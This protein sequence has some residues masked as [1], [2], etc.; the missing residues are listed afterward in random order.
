MSEP[1]WMIT[2]G[3]YS[4]YGV[5]A[6]FDHRADAEIALRAGMGDRIEEI[7]RIPVGGEVVRWHCVQAR[8][9]LKADGSD[10]HPPQTWDLYEPQWRPK[11]ATARRPPEVDIEL[12]DGRTY[13]TVLAETEEI[14]MKV[15]R[16]RV[17]KTRAEIMGL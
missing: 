6:V 9:V 16:E 2:A 7:M 1:L 13:I 11:L 15:L 10:L 17:A 8:C 5:L 14:A 3:E 4:D 12:E